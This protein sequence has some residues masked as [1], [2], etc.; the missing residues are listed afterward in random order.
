M[1]DIEV[2]IYIPTD[3]IQRRREQK[4]AHGELLLLALFYSSRRVSDKD[5]LFIRIFADWYFRQLN[6]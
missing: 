4:F 2:K 3:L 5:A 1:G 6:F